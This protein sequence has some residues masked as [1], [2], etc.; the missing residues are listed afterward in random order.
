MPWR[1]EVELGPDLTSSG[2]VS[3]FTPGRNRRNVR[4]LSLI[5]MN[6]T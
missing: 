5:D 6:V 1:L 4:R 2:P 3:A